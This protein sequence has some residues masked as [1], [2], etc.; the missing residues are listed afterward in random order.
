LLIARVERVVPFGAT[1]S[2][3]DVAVGVAADYGVDDFGQLDHRILWSPSRVRRG[4]STRAR[5]TVG[6]ICEE[7]RTRRE[8]TGF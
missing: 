7:S 3:V 5:T 1:N 8:R 6:H 4:T 2:S